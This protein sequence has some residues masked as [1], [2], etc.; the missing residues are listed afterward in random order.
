MINLADVLAASNGQYDSV[1]NVLNSAQ[2]VA[3]SMSVCFVLALVCISVSANCYASLHLRLSFVP[4][5]VGLVSGVLLVVGIVYFIVP[6]TKVQ[7]SSPT[8]L[9]LVETG[10]NVEA[11]STSESPLS[12]HHFVD[13]INK[14]ETAQVSFDDNGCVLNTIVVTDDSSNV[15]VIN[16]DTNEIVQPQVSD[17]EEVAK[18]LSEK[19]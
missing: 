13:N 3:L 12:T 8:V 14:G 19:Y 11:L 5:V 16:T 15:Y 4:K 1:V 6:Y 2:P 7:Y 18:L 17:S 9:D 10:Y